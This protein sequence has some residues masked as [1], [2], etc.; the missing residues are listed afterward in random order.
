MLKYSRREF[1][2]TVAADLILSPRDFCRNGCQ[3]AMS[4]FGVWI[5]VF[6]W[7]MSTCFNEALLLLPSFV[8][9]FNRRTEFPSVR[10]EVQRNI[11]VRV[12]PQPNLRMTQNYSESK[13]A[14][15]KEAVLTPMI[16]KFSVAGRS[17]LNANFG[18]AQIP[19][20]KSICY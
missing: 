8:L 16:T 10:L 12:M 7:Q 4:E 14:Q 20:R 15:I 11:P 19:G 1:I 9:I 3:L 13:C 17:T 6:V 18:V 5:V 2:Y